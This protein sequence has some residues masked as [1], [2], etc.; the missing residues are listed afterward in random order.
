V[1]APGLRR[2][3]LAALAEPQPPA[4]D[5]G[6]DDRE[7]EHERGQREGG[8]RRGIDQHAADGDRDHGPD[9]RGD[10]LGARG[11]RPAGVVHVL[12][13]DRAVR[14]RQRVEPG[15]DERR[16]QPERDV[17]RAAAQSHRDQTAAGE[18]RAA[19]DVGQPAAAAVGPDADC[20]RDREPRQ[21]VDGHHSADERRGVL[22]PLEQQRQVGGGQRAAG[23]GSHRR[24]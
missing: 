3:R 13:H 21:R 18:E 4:H 15:V 5:H 22:D 9:E 6:R 12:R 24:Q 11:G 10:L 23:A 16:G 19:G 17:G 14:G 7:G 20:D 2:R 8:G 1:G